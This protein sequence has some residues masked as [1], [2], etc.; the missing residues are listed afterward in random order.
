MGHPTEPEAVTPQ[1]AKGPCWGATRID[2]LSMF[3]GNLLQVYVALCSI[4]GKSGECFPSRQ[5]IATKAGGVKMRTL[6]YCLAKL[7]AM[8]LIERTRRGK[9]LNNRWVVLNHP[10]SAQSESPQALRITTPQDSAKSQ[11]ESQHSAE[12][13][14][15]SVQSESQQAWQLRSK[16][17]RSKEKATP[18]ET[19]TSV[20][21]DLA[22]KLEPDPSS[23]ESEPEPGTLERIRAN[24]KAK[25]TAWGGDEAVVPASPADDLILQG[26][27]CKLLAKREREAE[28]KARVARSFGEQL[29]VDLEDSRESD[30]VEADPSPAP[31][32]VEPVDAAPTHDVPRK[33]REWRVDR[34][35]ADAKFC[36]KFDEWHRM[37]R[38]MGHDEL[39]IRNVVRGM[40]VRLANGQ[41]IGD[42]YAYMEP[43]LRQRKRC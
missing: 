36:G 4:Q 11:S 8:G 21:D 27:Q 20:A 40:N 37:E 7:V 22:V 19:S 9:K 26:A 41:A 10:L 35:A 2:V 42:P 16:R 29:A 43:M 1:V 14:A 33:L 18:K 3:P 23:R 31:V 17:L 25:A 12:C 34:L 6:D 28:T 5:T 32:D 30:P 24:I 39:K 38:D 13:V 15:I